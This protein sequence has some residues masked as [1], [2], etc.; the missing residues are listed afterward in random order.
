MA[1]SKRDVIAK[2]SVR[3]VTTMTVKERKMRRSCINTAALPTTRRSSP[4]PPPRA[5]GVCAVM[6][7]V[8]GWCGLGDRKNGGQALSKRM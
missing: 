1:M 4:R 3:P 6:M 7:V 2:A 8:M 5:I